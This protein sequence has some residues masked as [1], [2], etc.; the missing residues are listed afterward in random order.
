MNPL[1]SLPDRVYQRIIEKKRRLELRGGMTNSLAEEI[2]KRM[3]VEFV[4]NSNKIEGNTLSRGETELILQGVTIRNTDLIGALAGKNVSDILAVQNHPDAISFVKEM[5]F[6]RQRKV[7]EADIKEL[8]RVIMNGIISSAG[9]YRTFDIQVRGAGFTPPP[10]YMVHDEMKELVEFVN[11]NDHELRPIELAAHAHY[12]LTWIHPFEDGNGRIS[13]LLLNLIL[14]R[15]GYPFAVIRNVERKQYL[16]S[17]RRADRGE[18]Q[19][20][21]NYIARCVEQ[22]MD[23]YLMELEGHRGKRPRLQSMS[24]L[25]KGT[26]YSAEY[27]SL[28]ARKGMIDAVRE[29]RIWKSTRKN[30][31]TYIA[32]HGRRRK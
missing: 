22:T 11:R 5:A 17:L 4:Y 16:E 8:H 21:L 6:N 20:F 7:T 13:R 3:Q 29:G 28:L 23:L 18:F 19:P 14:I 10:F 1:A 9:Q 32:E 24:E 27:L 12:F 25:A 15:F 2:A 26:P 30:I 31:D